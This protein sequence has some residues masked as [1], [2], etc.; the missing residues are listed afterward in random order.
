MAE[1]FSPTRRIK[2][3]VD[4][5]GAA[6]DVYVFRS[7]LTKAFT[8]E[9]NAELQARGDES[10]FVHWDEV[11]FPEVTSQ[12]GGHRAGGPGRASFLTLL[13]PFLVR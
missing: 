6:P 3:S 8:D 1:L 2:A 9:V 4:R 11:T 10:V 5:P 13:L 7:T 12:K